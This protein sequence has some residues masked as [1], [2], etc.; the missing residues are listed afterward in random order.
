MLV[1]EVFVH[2]STPVLVLNKQLSLLWKATVTNVSDDLGETIME[3][4]Y[5]IQLTILTKWLSL[6]VLTH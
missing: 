4:I 5:Y 3:Y 2:L 6:T 1:E